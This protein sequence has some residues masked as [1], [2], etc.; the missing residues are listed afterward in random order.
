MCVSQSLPPLKKPILTVAFDHHEH[1]ILA[2]TESGVLKV[3]DLERLRGLKSLKGHRT[4]I[5]CVDWHP[6][7][8][9]ICASGGLDT[10]VKLWDVRLKLEYMTYKGHSK[11]VRS[12]EFSPDGRWAASGSDDNKVIVRERRWNNPVFRAQGLCLFPPC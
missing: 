1:N 9:G 3:F 12:I 6:Y 2:G 8:R 4:G 7:N 11:P 5:G 10:L